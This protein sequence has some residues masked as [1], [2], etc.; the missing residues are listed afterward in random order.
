MGPSPLPLEFREDLVSSRVA[1]D[2]VDA[3]AGL[4]WDQLAESDGC[5]AGRVPILPPYVSHWSLIP[6][7]YFSFILLF[8]KLG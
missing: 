8:Y 2:V 4:L 6:F 5:V 1:L 3:E 7:S